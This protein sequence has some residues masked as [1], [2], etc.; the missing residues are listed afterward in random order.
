VNAQLLIKYYIP[1][2]Y[3]DLQLLTRTEL[4][5]NLVLDKVSTAIGK[6]QVSS[7]SHGSADV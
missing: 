1:L 6:S 5:E 4:A 2:Q 3:F 7:L